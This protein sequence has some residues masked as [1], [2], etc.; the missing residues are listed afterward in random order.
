[1]PCAEDSVSV[2]LSMQCM[3]FHQPYVALVYQVPDEILHDVALNDAIA[4]LPSNYSFE[5][6]ASSHAISSCCRTH[7]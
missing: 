3:F 2:A 1:M 4:V 5:V 6:G 7:V